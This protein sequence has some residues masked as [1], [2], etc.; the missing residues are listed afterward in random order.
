MPPAGAAAGCST[1]P[2]MAA[3]PNMSV[4]M[5]F[6]RGLPVGMSLCGRAWSE[7]T[8]IRL[9]YAFEQATNVRRPPT[10]QATVQV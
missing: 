1:P 6:I 5:G 7:A 2:A 8:L 10:F 3:Y 4:P 9:A